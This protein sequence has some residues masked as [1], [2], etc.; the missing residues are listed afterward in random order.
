MVFIVMRSHLVVLA[1]AVTAQSC[2]DCTVSHHNAIR[3]RPY[4]ATRACVSLLV[5]MCVYQ[6][7]LNTPCGVATSSLVMM[8]HDG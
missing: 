1:L 6:V 8:T 4:D 2:R 5:C 7:G 3:L